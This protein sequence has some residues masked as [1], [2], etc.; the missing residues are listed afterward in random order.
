MIDG[1]SAGPPYLQ[2]A[3]DAHGLY[4]PNG[5]KRTS[6][7]YL[8]GAGRLQ[9]MRKVRGKGGTGANWGILTRDGGWEELAQREILWDYGQEYWRLHGAGERQNGPHQPPKDA[10]AQRKK[11][12]GGPTPIS[13]AARAASGTDN[14]P[15]LNDRRT[16][17]RGK[18]TTRQRSGTGSAS[19][20]ESDDGC[21]GGADTG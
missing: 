9:S 17:G 5:S 4:K 2:R 1:T 15:P 13:A 19:S 7:A 6:T 20:E 18:R 8:D 12:A 16:N 3:N 14:A 11:N 21:A 10:N